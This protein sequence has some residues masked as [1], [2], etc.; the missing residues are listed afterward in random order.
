M[1]VT[2]KKTSPTKTLKAK[3]PIRDSENLDATRDRK[4]ERMAKFTAFTES[5]THYINRLL[6]YY[7]SLKVCTENEDCT[8]STA[9]LLLLLW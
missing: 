5:F 2:S 4:D 3:K 8:I 7:A 9:F 1:A 6:C